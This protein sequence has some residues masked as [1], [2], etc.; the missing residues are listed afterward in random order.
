MPIF[1]FKNKCEADPI[2]LS[3]ALLHSKGLKKIPD[4]IA[5]SPSGERVVIEI[6]RYVKTPKWYVEIISAHT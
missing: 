1:C 4:A 2:G 5:T 3:G 6:E